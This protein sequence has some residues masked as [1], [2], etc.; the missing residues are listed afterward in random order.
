[1]G[2][3]LIGQPFDDPAYCW[4]RRSAAGPYPYNAEASSGSNLGLTN[5][6][7][8]EA[9]Q[10]RSDTLRAAEYPVPRAA[11]ARGLGKHLVRDLVAAHTEGR[12]LG[13]LDALAEVE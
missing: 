4:G 7:L 12:W 3:N 8:I 1:M 6:A 9:I 11:H 13:I 2:S 5:P 10:A